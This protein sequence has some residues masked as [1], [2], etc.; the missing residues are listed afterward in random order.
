[1]NKKLMGIALVSQLVL[2]GCATT[3]THFGVRD[4][5]GHVPKW[6]D[7]A[8]AVIARAEA[9]PGARACP[10]QMARAKKYAVQAMD[11]YWSCRDAEAKMM[12]AEARRLAAEAEACGAPAANRMMELS[13]DALFAFD[14]ADLTPQGV[15]TLNEFL[16]NL[17]NTSF[18]GILIVG[19]TDPIG[20]EAYNQRLSERRA[21]AVAR[22][23][24]SHGVPG[25]RAIAQGRGERELKVTYQQCAAQGAKKGAAL[26][27]C[28][29]PN[30]RVTVDV[31]GAVP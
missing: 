21:Q 24:T 31:T 15:A 6:I 3:N 14:K 18:N 2:V 4:R 11:V 22:Y 5:A 1:M 26:I 17:V 9:S 7:E 8:E 10:D 20:P 13:A 28:F 30:R 12:L 19:H 25:D 29:Q 16:R 23:L 27:N